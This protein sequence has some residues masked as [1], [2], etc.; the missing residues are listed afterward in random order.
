MAFTPADLYLVPHTLFVQLAFVSF[1]LAVL[2]YLPAVLLTPGYPKVYAWTYLAFALLLASDIWLLFFRPSLSTS[3][4][5][6]SIHVTG[7]KVIVYAA[8]LTMFIQAYG[9][10]RLTRASSPEFLPAR[11]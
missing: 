6:L 5:G 11:Q 2:F 8:I 9:A 1:F 3:S 10:W 7:Q 4:L